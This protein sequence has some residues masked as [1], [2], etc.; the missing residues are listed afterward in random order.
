MTVI[1]SGVLTIEALKASNYLQKNHNIAIEVIDLISIK[2]IDYENIIRSLCKTR[3]ILVI[4]SG[5]TTCSI[6]S[7]IIA[8]ISENHFDKLDLPPM[9][10]AMPDC[11]EP[12]S[13]GL[14]KGFH[15]RAGDIANRILKCLDVGN[16]EGITAIPEPELHDIPGDWFNGPF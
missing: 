5:Y 4:D 10:I 2:P 14:T 13:F 15:I 12:T 16:N 7:E 3:K 6:A 11:P 9:K 1:S 8:Y